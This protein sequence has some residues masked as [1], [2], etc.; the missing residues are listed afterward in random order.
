LAA[1]LGAPLDPDTVHVLEIA[2][3]RSG[4]AL[5]PLVG[6]LD[7]PERA[8][9]RGMPAAR[10]RRHF[11]TGRAV[12]RQLLAVRTGVP[13]PRVALTFGPHGKV[14]GPGAG[15]AFNLAHAGA[16]LTIALTSRLAVGVDVEDRFT[17]AQVA[18]LAPRILDADEAVDLAA[19]P[20][21]RRPALLRR[22]W[23]AKE[24]IMKARGLGFALKPATI[25]LRRDPHGLHER[26]GAWTLFDWPID[27]IAHAGLALPGAAPARLVRHRR[28]AAALLAELGGAD[29]ARGRR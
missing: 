9:A 21:S 10:A 2:I 22:Y 19:A 7:G 1:L 29:P 25:A 11:V 14:A 12:L 17:A 8:R 27:H 4:A 3:P 13:A 26:A 23:V 20:P 6:L 16:W 5:A 18:R 24:A 15:L 28:T